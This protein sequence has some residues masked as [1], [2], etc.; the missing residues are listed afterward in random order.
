MK[1]N[2]GNKCQPKVLLRI[3]TMLIRLPEVSARKQAL[4]HCGAAA[5]AITATND[6]EVVQ[7]VSTN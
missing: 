4:V 3:F 1:T 2:N 7:H 5:A 6:V